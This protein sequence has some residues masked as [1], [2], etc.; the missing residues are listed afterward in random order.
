MGPELLAVEAWKIWDLNEILSQAGFTPQGAD[1]GL[2]PGGRSCHHDVT[3]VAL[4]PAPSGK[5]CRKKF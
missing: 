1:A 5:G 3:P 4:P 2:R